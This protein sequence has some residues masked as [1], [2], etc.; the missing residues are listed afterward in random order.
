MKNHNLIKENRLNKITIKNSEI[1]LPSQYYSFFDV[2]LPFIF[3]FEQLYSYLL[4]KEKN[5]FQISKKFIL[6]YQSNLCH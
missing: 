2:E 4:S 3:T 1:Y 6:I 5:N